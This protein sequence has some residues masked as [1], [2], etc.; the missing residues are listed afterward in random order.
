MQKPGSSSM[1]PGDAIN[2]NPGKQT[3]QDRQHVSVFLSVNKLQGKERD[4]RTNRVK[5]I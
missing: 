2:K 4:G 3:L 5:D 1:T